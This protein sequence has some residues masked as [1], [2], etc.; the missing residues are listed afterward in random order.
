M[1]SGQY[2]RIDVF[3][4]GTVW[5]GVS[6]S[7]PVGT[8]FTLGTAHGS[9]ARARLIESGADIRAR[10]NS[11]TACMHDVAA[12][13]KRNRRSLSLNSLRHEIG[14]TLLEA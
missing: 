4:S 9:Y 1:R 5:A 11:V 3:F 8:I 12:T 7:R 13:N 6:I 14:E 10:T 2:F